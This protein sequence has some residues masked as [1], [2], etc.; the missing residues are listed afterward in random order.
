M[1]RRLEERRKHAPTWIQY[2][3]F[4]VLFQIKFRPHQTNE[5]EVKQKENTYA[6]VEWTGKKTTKY[7]SDARI[8][9]N[10]IKRT[11]NSQ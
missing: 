2:T 9:G 7:Q 5:D 10:A 8:M 1:A 6:W 3:L 11:S 4:G